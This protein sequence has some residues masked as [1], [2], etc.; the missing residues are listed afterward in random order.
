MF[1]VDLNIVISTLN[2][3]S[4]TENNIL[5]CSEES[6]AVIL[7]TFFSQLACSLKILL[8][9]FLPSFFPVYWVTKWFLENIPIFLYDRKA[10][11]TITFTW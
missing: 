10:Y 9:F 6:P 4:S 11:F 8:I 5:E 7:I 3:M 2:G 1:E